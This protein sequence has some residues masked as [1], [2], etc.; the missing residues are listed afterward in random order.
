[1]S[2]EAPPNCQDLTRSR[3]QPTL[4]NQRSPRFR[5]SNR[6]VCVKLITA[7]PVRTRERFVVCDVVFSTLTSMAPLRF[8]GSFAAVR[9]SIL[10]DDSVSTSSVSLTF[11]RVNDVPQTVRIH[12]GVGESTSFGPV[13]VPTPSGWFQS[14]IRV[15]GFAALR[16]PTGYLLKK[17]RTGQSIHRNPFVVLTHQ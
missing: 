4:T 6:R 15:A 14:T 12:D 2:G 7:P 8:Q 1:M 5:F 10:I 17:L 16:G 9:A 3:K 13:M 11:V